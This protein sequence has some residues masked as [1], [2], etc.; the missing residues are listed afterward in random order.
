MKC[1]WVMGGPFNLISDCVNACRPFDGD[2][3]VNAFDSNCVAFQ[4]SQ[5]MI[6]PNISANT[7]DKHSNIVKSHT[8]AN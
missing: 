5:C 3:N 2:V 4:H 6:E 1:E 7:I 8:F